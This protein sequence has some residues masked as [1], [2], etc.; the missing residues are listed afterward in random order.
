MERM[1]VQQWVD[2]G[3]EQEPTDN[4]SF[5]YLVKN[6]S[7]VLVDTYKPH[8]NNFAMSVVDNEGTFSNMIVPPNAVGICMDNDIGT[9]TIEQ[10][11]TLTK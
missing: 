2:N 7:V 1:T 11:E 6:G 8:G 4:F 3:A 10:F 9:P 5:F